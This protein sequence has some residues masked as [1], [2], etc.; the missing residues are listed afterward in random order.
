MSRYGRVHLKS[1]ED[2]VCK[3]DNLLQMVGKLELPE[4]WSRTARRT[5]LLCLGSQDSTKA[6]FH[7]Y[8]VNIVYML[9]LQPS[10]FLLTDG[11]LQGAHLSL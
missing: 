6:H 11:A 10:V 7:S 8:T 9:R 2:N 5:E 3:G 1:E 4:L